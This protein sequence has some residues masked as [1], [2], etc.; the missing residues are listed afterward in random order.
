MTHAVLFHL[1]LPSLTKQF[2]TYR[3]WVEH[4]PVR[5]PRKPSGAHGSVY[6]KSYCHRRRCRGSCRPKA[7]RRESR[8]L[9]ST[10][11]SHSPRVSFHPPQ[12]TRCRPHRYAQL[13]NTEELLQHKARHT[14]LRSHAEAAIRSHSQSIF[15]RQEYRIISW[16]LSIR[17]SMRQRLR[18]TAQVQ[19]LHAAQSHGRARSG[20]RVRHGETTMPQRHHATHQR[21]WRQRLRRRR[22][23]GECWQR[24]KLAGRAGRRHSG[25]RHQKS[26]RRAHEKIRYSQDKR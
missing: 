23:G 26:C 22:L 4:L 11:F 7:R 24:R 10:R 8:C 25:P 15:L 19:R 16:T 5:R 1:I 21:D 12:L 2:H 3:S 9:R 18:G 6:H 17:D 20:D 14:Q 13:H